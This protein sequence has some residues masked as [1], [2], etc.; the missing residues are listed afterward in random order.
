M[1]ISFARISIV[2]LVVV[3]SGWG[4]LRA[5]NL[6]P[7]PLKSTG[8]SYCGLY[9]LYAA[10][11]ALNRPIPFANL[12]QEKYIGSKKGSSLEELERAALDHGLHCRPMRSMSPSALRSADCPILLHV[13]RPGK[14]TPYDHW[15]LFLG[16]D[17]SGHDARIIDPPSELTTVP[18]SEICAL[19]DGVGLLV[20]DRPDRFGSPR[21][22]SWMN[23]FLTVAFVGVFVGLAAAIVKSTRWLIRVGSLLAIGVAA[24]A[25]WHVLHPDGMFGKRAALAQVAGRYFTPELP[26]LDATAVESSLRDFDVAVI[27]A[28]APDAYRYGH[29]PNAINMPVFTNVSQRD[30]ILRDVPPSRR[31]IVYCQNE[32]CP[33]AEAIGSDLSL[34]GYRVSIFP[35]G[36]DGWREFHRDR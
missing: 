14:G 27:D 17:E 4:L 20:G 18:L 33:W 31:V 12:L 8:G 22:G 34:R 23:Q 11:V 9:S 35:R 10:S 15:V 6:D 1:T 2:P 28:R 25:I 16:M 13:R 36:Y 5:D 30:R 7:K 3:L 21:L 24:S 26:V 32:H 19:W 29:L